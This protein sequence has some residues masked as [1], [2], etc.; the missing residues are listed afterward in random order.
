MNC[1]MWLGAGFNCVKECRFVSI[2]NLRFIYEDSRANVKTLRKKPAALHFML[3][4]FFFTPYFSA[5][6]AIQMYNMHI[7]QY[8]KT[9][10][11]CFC[12][13]RYV[14]GKIQF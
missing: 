14:F 2:I 3:H 7:P 11:Y 6:C 1:R 10:R 9:P 4:I 8:S 13:A 12:S 5:H